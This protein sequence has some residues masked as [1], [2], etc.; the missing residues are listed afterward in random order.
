M[1]RLSKDHTMLAAASLLAA[2]SAAEMLWPHPIE[3]A[4]QQTDSAPAQSA[5]PEIH[6]LELTQEYALA[7]EQPLFT[8]DRHPYVPPPSTQP[9]ASASQSAPDI[10]A[11]LFGVVTVAAERLVLLRMNGGQSVRK[12]RSGEAIDGW[13]VERVDEGSVTLVNGTFERRLEIS[14]VGDARR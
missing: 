8:V 2:A 14:S 6:R 3:V 13:T 5:R 10:S 12:L 9:A 11:E 1:I 4:T 7:I